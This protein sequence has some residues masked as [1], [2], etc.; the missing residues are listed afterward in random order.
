M[1]PPSTMY[2]FQLFS[3]SPEAANATSLSKT[4]NDNSQPTV[5]LDIPPQHIYGPLPTTPPRPSPSHTSSQYN[6]PLFPAYNPTLF[7]SPVLLQAQAQS[8]TL[9]EGNLLQLVCNSS[10]AECSRVC[11]PN[12]LVPYLRTGPLWNQYFDFSMFFR[13]SQSSLAL[14]TYSP[15]PD[16]P[17]HDRPS[18]NSPIVRT[19]SHASGSMDKSAFNV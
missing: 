15:Y 19:P 4:R 11:I 8:P 16:T 9:S 2:L 13:R 14:Y 5:S 6:G 10:R 7:R 3:L 1:D 17:Q 18:N 12:P